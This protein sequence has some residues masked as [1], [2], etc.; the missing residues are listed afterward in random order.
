VS[1]E[2]PQKLDYFTSSPLLRVLRDVRD[3]GRDRKGQDAEL[4]AVA[5]RA[6]AALAWFEMDM[7]GRFE[8]A[9]RFLKDTYPPEQPVA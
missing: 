2:G 9:E 3:L 6:H 8:E 4:E 7:E 5:R 1:S